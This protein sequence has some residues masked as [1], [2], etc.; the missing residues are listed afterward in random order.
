[1]LAATDIDDANAGLVYTVNNQFNGNFRLVSAPTIPITTFTQDDIDNNRVLF[2][3]DG[4]EQDGIVEFSVADD[5]ADGALPATGTFT[6]TKIDVN[7]APTI[8]VNTGTSVNQNSIVILK[9]SVLA[10][11]D[12]DDAPSGIDYTIDSTSG[13]QLEYLANPNV[14]ITTFTQEDIDNSLVVFRHADPAASASFDFTVSD[15]GEDLAGTA[16]GTFNLTVDN[17]NDS[18]EITTNAAP[19]MNEGT[20]ITLNTTMLDS[21]DPDDFG[22]E[23]TC[24]ATNLQSGTLQVGGIAQNSF[25][26]EDLDNS[27][28]TFT[29]DGSQTV[30]AGFTVTLADGGEN[31]ATTDTE[32]FRINV[33][34]IN[35]LPSI[36]ANTGDTLDEGA[37]T[38]IDNTK[39][40]TSDSDVNEADWYNGDWDYRQKITLN[41]DYVDAD[42][43]D[44]TLLISGDNFS[45]DFWDNVR[46]DGNDIVITLADGTKLSRE[47]VSINRGAE[48]M[49]LHVKVPNVSSTIDTELF[50]YYGNFAASE[51]N[52][53]AAV[54]ANYDHVYHM[55]ELNALDVISANNG[56]NSGGGSITTGIM[57]NAHSYN[58]AG[59]VDITTIAGGDITSVSFWYNPESQ[60][61]GNYGSLLGSNSYNEG[62]RHT[63]TDT[64]NLRDNG[65]V[66]LSS[67]PSFDSYKYMVFSYD[68]GAST[69]N[70]YE[71]GAL[72][73]S[74]AF[75]GWHNV[76]HLIGISGA[77]DRAI[78]GIVDEIRIT[79][80][81][82]TQAQAA[83]EYANQSTPSLFYSLSGQQQYVPEVLTYTITTEALNGTLYLDANTNGSLDGGEA[84]ALNDTFTQDDIDAGL[85][86]YSHDGG[87]TISDNFGFTISDAD[88]TTAAQTFS[89]TVTPVND[90]PVIS[91][92]TGP[93]INEGDSVTLTTAMLDVTDPDDANSDLLWSASNLSNGTIEVNGS[94]QNTFTH[95]QLVNGDVAFIHDGGET[96]AAGFDISVADDEGASDSGSFTITITPVN[97]APTLILNDGDP[98]VIDLNDYTING[99]GGAQD[100]GGTITVSADGSTLTMSN[101]NMWKQI[102]TPYTLTANTVLSFEF[103]A[104][105]NLEVQGIGFENDAAFGFLGYQLYGS[106]NWI[107]NNDYRTYQAGDGWV[108]YDID[109]GS[110]YTGVMNSLVFAM[111]NDVNINGTQAFRNINFYE[112]DQIVDMDEGGALTLINAHLNS[113]DPDDT[114]DNRIFTATNLTNGHIEVAGVTQNTFT[115]ADINNGDVVFIHDDSETLT[116]GFD[117]AL[118]DD[119]GAGTDTGALILS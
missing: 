106:Q 118:T 108:R 81:V 36:D 56:T 12:T 61:G 6:I 72:Q 35:N 70:L 91:T 112:A 25:T 117:I 104:D 29:H 59:K 2:Q 95:A 64:L 105:T 109:I 86:L 84:L 4:N 83:A 21:F 23:L 22:T 19:A 37:T 65:N 50:I 45:R 94:A 13:G 11:A 34:Q 43:T 69:I 103:F 8:A 89:F 76:E 100:A 71:N 75:A 1:M 63:G 38:T 58:G 54:F 28:V 73:D 77:T 119:G 90:V 31:D 51:T 115:Q 14:A 17:T 32:F 74:S 78:D 92:N 26:Q 87:E 97:D 99:Y 96:I 55:N 41:S 110:D 102:T 18:P 66:I 88:G 3:H 53:A 30:S 15:G 82:I 101:G 44:F 79:G 39:L 7:D 20:T 113:V 5:G 40:S 24:T 10:A 116:A 46:P 93:T 114:P 49:E 16:S 48:T 107:V 68:A 98:N 9:N 57:G 80:S 42:L 60:G 33:T 111:D 47:L 52:D 62:I 67:S 27:D 85:L